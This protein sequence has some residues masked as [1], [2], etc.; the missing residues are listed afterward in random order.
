MNTITLDF[1]DFQ[2]LNIGFA[3]FNMQLRQEEQGNKICPIP[4]FDVTGTPLTSLFRGGFSPLFLLGHHITTRNHQRSI[5][6]TI[7]FY[8]KL[9][10]EE[11]TGPLMD[12]LGL[13]VQQQTPV[14][15]TFHLLLLLMPPPPFSF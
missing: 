7:R 5:G 12:N 10:P 14:F 8:W 2:E 9:P 1:N 4:I 11:V 6:Y 15:V 3:H 13:P